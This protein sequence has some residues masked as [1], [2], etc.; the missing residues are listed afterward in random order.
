MILII[1]ARIDGSDNT[2][3]IPKA[4]EEIII[5]VVLFLNNP[6]IAFLKIS[7]STIGP[8]NTADITMRITPLP[9]KDSMIMA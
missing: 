6:K 4:K 8:S 1:K 5:A 3:M 7:S 9:C 2:W